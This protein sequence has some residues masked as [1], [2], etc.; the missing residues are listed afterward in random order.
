MLRQ[1]LNSWS[2]LAFSLATKDWVIRRDIEI[3]GKNNAFSL[4]LRNYLLGRTG[5]VENMIG[6]V[7]GK[8]ESKEEKL[9]GSYQDAS[10]GVFV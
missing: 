10:G 8:D 5:G 7:K 6:N 3:F 1:A 4:Q 9:P 2:A